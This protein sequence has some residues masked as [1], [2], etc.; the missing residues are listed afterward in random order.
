MGF[1]SK[2]FKGVGKVFSQNGRGLKKLLLNS[3]NLWKDRN[4]WSDW[5]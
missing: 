2:V 5:S 1:F 3:A 4:H